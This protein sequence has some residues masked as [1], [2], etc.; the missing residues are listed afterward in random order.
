MNELEKYSIKE[1]RQEIYRRTK[2][3]RRKNKKRTCF[4]CIHRISASE[5]EKRQRKGILPYKYYS[6]GFNPICLVRQEKAK[7][8]DQEYHLNVWN[9]DK[10]CELFEPKERFK[11]E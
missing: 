4:Q 2:E 10:A 7:Y 8:K 1:L 6:F 9:T 3:E 11:E 5:A